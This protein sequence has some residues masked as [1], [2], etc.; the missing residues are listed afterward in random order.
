MMTKKERE[1]QRPM[2]MQNKTPFWNGI[3]C[4]DISEIAYFRAIILLN[5]QS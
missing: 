1:H 5:V 2:R 3:R 4:T